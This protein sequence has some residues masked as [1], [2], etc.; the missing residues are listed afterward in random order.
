MKLTESRIK[1]IIQEE[2]EAIIEDE[3]KKQ[4]FGAGPALSSSSRA[5]ALKKA[6]NKMASKS[7]FVLIFNCLEHY[8]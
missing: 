3:E 2:I 5:S 8:K 7:T 1:Q 4:K 6:P